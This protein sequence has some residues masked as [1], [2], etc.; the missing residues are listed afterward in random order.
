[1]DS[2]TVIENFVTGA[3][4]WF[5]AFN[6][7]GAATKVKTDM[8]GA[9]QLFAAYG[10]TTYE[11]T[12]VLLSPIRKVGNDGLD[13][14]NAMIV[15]N[16]ARSSDSYDADPVK[17]PFTSIKIDGTDLNITPV[18]RFNPQA[19]ENVELPPIPD[20][21]GGKFYQHI[22]MT[23]SGALSMQVIIEAFLPN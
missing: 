7:D 15:T 20:F 10:D 1:M 9:Y 23:G 3:E 14:F 21:F 5:K 17:A 22:P 2:N 19:Q 12:P 8:V 4:P 18:E 13:S 11:D 6:A 16:S